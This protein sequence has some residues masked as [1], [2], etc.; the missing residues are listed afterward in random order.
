V[1]SK[2]TRRDPWLHTV[3]MMHEGQA[4]TL[5][6][7]QRLLTAEPARLKPEAFTDAR[8]VSVVERLTTTTAIVYWR[9]ATRCCYRDQTW[10]SARARR[11]GSC[12]ISGRPIH[13]GDLIYVPARRAAV[14]NGQAMILACV[15]EH[16][17]LLAQ[18]QSRVEPESACKC[19]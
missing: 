7:L 10:I 5:P 14:C 15:I 13:R 2:P 16:E 11:S 9:D 8:T 12:A 4:P 18:E 3:K 19:S 17:T 1:S 6:L